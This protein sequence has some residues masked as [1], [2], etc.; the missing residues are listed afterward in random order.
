M[1]PSRGGWDEE[2]DAAAAR[3]RAEE[4]KRHFQVGPDTR[5]LL[6][7][8]RL[9]PEKGIHLILEALSRLERAGRG[10]KDVCLFVCGEAAFM[11]GTSYARRLRRL[12]SRFGRFR[13]F[14]PGYVSAG[15]KHAFLSLADLFLSP[16]VHDSYGLTVV[17]AL[18]AGVPV[19]ASD[20]H[21][22][23]EIFAAPQA[24]DPERGFGRTVSYASG[25]SAGR[26]AD[27]L[28]GLLADP[29]ALAAMGERAAHAGAAMRFS[30]AARRIAEAA[31]ELAP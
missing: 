31:L 10:P 18:R 16:S 19:L 25:D 5:V 4:L 28:E 12:A 17:E 30:D 26:L 6:T 7:L 20:H 27:A 22:V 8:S 21:G 9:S 29:R 13:I 2:F 1:R 14:F 3:S 15:E 11:S 23:R 24:C